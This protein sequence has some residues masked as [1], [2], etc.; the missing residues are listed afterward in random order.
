[1]DSIES[2]R[3][4]KVISSKLQNREEGINEI[5]NQYNINTQQNF[6]G[7]LNSISKMW[8]DLDDEH[9]KSLSELMFGKYYSNKF[10]VIMDN[11]EMNEF[12]D[13]IFEEFPYLAPIMIMQGL[14]VDNIRE[15]I[16]KITQCKDSWGD[17]FS[18]DT[19]ELYIKSYL[20]NKNSKRGELFEYICE[21]NGLNE[22]LKALID[23]Y[24]IALR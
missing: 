19:A 17:N 11:F 7:I 15:F 5:L 20:T 14:D 13:G 12:V 21:T 8:N 22:D 23:S 4:L 6:Y 2:G 16:N 1:M 10:K 24:K 18:K 3:V 9:K